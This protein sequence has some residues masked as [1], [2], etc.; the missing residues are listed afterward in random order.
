MLLSTEYQCSM[1]DQR[2]SSHHSSAGS[3][4]IEEWDD[5]NGASLGHRSSAT[6]GLLCSSVSR[7]L[8]RA[9]PDHHI[10]LRLLW[11]A[12]LCTG[13][14]VSIMVP[15]TLHQHDSPNRGRPAMDSR[16]SFSLRPFRRSA[17]STHNF[18]DRP[19]PLLRIHCRPGR[20]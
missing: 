15:I 6:S 14:V 19:L 7:H 18:P 11:D 8:P 9:S 2:T 10:I 17:L 5:N 13:K 16:T 20:I 4:T 1:L 12:S 3:R